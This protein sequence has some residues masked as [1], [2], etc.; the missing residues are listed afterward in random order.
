MVAIDRETLGRFRETIGPC[1]EAARL[2]AEAA[3]LLAAGDATEAA[4]RFAGALAT[5][6]A[7]FHLKVAHGLCE[8][9]LQL[10]RGAEAEP[11]SRALVAERPDLLTAHLLLGRCLLQ[12][13]REEDA[14]AVHRHALGL[15][16]GDALERA[17]IVAD[18]AVALDRLGR[19]AEGERW[20]L[21][22]LPGR[23]VA[24][25]SVYLNLATFRFRMGALEGAREAL[26]AARD[27][28]PDA[29]PTAEATWAT[30]GDGSPL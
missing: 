20:C 4:E 7:R 27:C 1:D 11:L 13:G 6:E 25:A 9:L 5:G 14:L 12:M 10:G 2:Y 24:D 16:I 15:D 29:A 22:A 18:G 3:V 8:A 17:R 30:Y 23:V 28:T 26:R 19:F 21:E